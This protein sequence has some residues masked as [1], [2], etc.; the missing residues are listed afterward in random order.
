MLLTS[1]DL[2]STSS[3]ENLLKTIDALLGMKVI[4]V[5]NGNDVVAPNPQRGMDLGNVSNRGQNFNHSLY[6]YMSSSKK[7]L[8]NFY[9]LADY[10]F[11]S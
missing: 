7:L 6:V 2:N 11:T 4:P 10:T 8:I 5:L 1:N 3:E 9:C